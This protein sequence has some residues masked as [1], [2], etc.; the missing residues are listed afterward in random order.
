MLIVPEPMLDVAVE[1]VTSPPVPSG[2]P[3]APLIISILPDKAVDVVLCPELRFTD[4]PTPLPEVP[5]AIDTSP[6]VPLA[7]PLLTE[8]PPVFPTDESEEKSVMSPDS[9]EALIV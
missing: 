9:A 4:P 3:A 7:T 6:D 5:A 1:M 8:T 2:A